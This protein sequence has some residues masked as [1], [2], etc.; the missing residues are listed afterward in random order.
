MLDAK[1]SF[2]KLIYSAEQMHK[3]SGSFYAQSKSVAF[4]PT[5]GNLHK[6]HLSLIEKARQVADVVVVSIFVNPKQFGENED[7]E[8][9]PKTL[10]RDESLCQQLNVDYIFA[11][12][13]QNIYPS[14]F[15]TKINGGELAGKYCGASRPNFFDGILTVVALLFQVVEPSVA[16][17]G[18]KDFQQLFLIRQMVRDLRMP[19]KILA[20]PIIR[21]PDGLAMSSRNNYLKP[22]QREIA[23]SLFNA[24]TEL[25][26]LYNQGVADAEL[27]LD[28]ARKIISGNSSMQL[29]Y[30]AFIDQ[31]TFAPAINKIIKPV[32][33]LLAANLGQ[34]PSIRLIDNALI[35]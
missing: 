21:E 16:V 11:P 12:Q 6:G 8:T 27:L 13:V 10:E 9:Y 29:E 23:L 2:C 24:I 30:A 19:V 35:G 25:K 1:D 7:F 34:D 33:L 22:W 17:F 31:Q 15:Q 32:R 14:G 28:E 5:M 26:K 20:A 3:L 18:E 4:V